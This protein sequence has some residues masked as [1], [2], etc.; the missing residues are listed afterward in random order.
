MRAV[1]LVEIGKPLELQEIPVPEIGMG[2][3]LVRVRA[4]GICHS[5]VHYRS[6]ASPVGSL[7]QTLGHE[8]AGVIEKTGSAVHNAEVG[9]RVALHYLLTCGDCYYCSMG[10]EQFCTSGRMIGKHCDGGY[11]DYIVVPARNAIRLPDEVPFEHG[12]ALMCS[13]STSY[14]ALKKTRLKPGETAAVF[15]A[16]GLGMAAIQLAKALGA[17]D[18]FAVDINPDKLKLAEEK[19]AIPI[20]AADGDPVEQIRSLTG[21]RGVDV[22]LELVGLKQTMEQA[23]RALAVFGRA[24]VVGIIG[25]PVEIETY[26]ELL[27]KEAEIIGCADHLL[28]EMPA[29]LEYARR[30]I[31]DFSDVMINQIPL[32]ADAVNHVFDELEQ[33]G[34]YVRTV[35]VP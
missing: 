3:V 30:G 22:A 18:V 26:T 27:G 32:D 28:Q 35:I 29:L 2:E 25:E 6:G 14:H 4:A 10:S 17:L 33:F 13:A 21:G 15:G 9:D 23:V 8:V 31:L 5:D 19:G 1:R 7:P 20:N 11:A 24:G 12:A 34:G 16:G